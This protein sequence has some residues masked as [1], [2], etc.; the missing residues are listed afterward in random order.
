MNKKIVVLISIFFFCAGIGGGIV[1]QKLFFSEEKKDVK[2]TYAAGWAA[3]KQRL[4]DTG[5]FRA[6]GN[7]TE[8]KSI[9]GIVSKIENNIITIKSQPIEL[10][11]DP[12]LDERTVDVDSNTKITAAIKK[13]DQQY[14]KEYNEALKNGSL[15]PD[16]SS[17]SAGI[18]GYYNENV[19]VSQIEIG[20]MITVNSNDDL[21]DKKKIVAKE[22]LFEK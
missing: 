19:S 15:K 9:S 13:S 21:K 7:N 6:V 3:A 5:A 14:Q 22:I 18:S 17:P 20:K 1:L 16:P 12:S 2:D 10:L 8:I 4:A 11:S